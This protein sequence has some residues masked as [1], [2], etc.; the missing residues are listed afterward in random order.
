[1]TAQIV[2]R[3]YMY[4]VAF[5]GLQLM[6]NGARGIIAVMLERSLNAPAIGGVASQTMQMSLFAA[7]LIVGLPLWAGHWWWAQRSLHN[8]DEQHSALRRLYGYA[9]LAV[10]MMS[11]LLDARELI[12]V[13]L[14]GETAGTRMIIVANTIG[15][16]VI[17]STVWLYHWRVFRAD[18]MVVETAGAPAT[19]RRW[20]LVI[21]LAWSLGFASYGAVDVLHQLLHLVGAPG[22]GSTAAIAWA[23]A[24]LIAGLAVWLPHQQWARSLV[25]RQTPLRANEVRSK[26]RQVYGALVITGA[27][28]AALGG[29]ATLLYWA[30]L[31][32]FGGAR[33]QQL[34]TEHTRSFSVVVVAT[35]VW[36]YHRAQLADEAQQSDLAGRTNTARRVV[37]YV[38]ATIG[39][40]GLFIGL[41]GLLSTMLQLLFAPAVFGQ[42]WRNSISFGVA[43]SVVA[44]PMY[45]LA[46][47]DMEHLAQASLDEEQTLARRIY[48]YGMLLFGII[49]TIVAVVS[50]LRLLIGALLG[51]PEPNLGAELARWLGYSV[52]SAT[53]GATYAMLLRRTIGNRAEI[54][55]GETIAIIAE[56]PL[57][58][59]LA[60]AISNELPGAQLQRVD[61]NG[62][63]SL[64]TATTLIVSLSAALDEPTLHALNMFTGRRVLLATETAG[65]NVIGKQT[66]HAVVRAAIRA[67]RTATSDGS[68]VITSTQVA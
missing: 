19:L 18:Q 50:V 60:T 61:A 11:L 40:V 4:I 52:I 32:L 59:A 47:R 34:I 29:L 38:T 13:L 15:V 22:I 6:I 37:G 35:V 63:N 30:L 21:V 17:N 67:I 10:A 25:Y 42:G 55:V 7:L 64:T 65:Y 53:I 9:L 43:L 27:L 5:I 44:F 46:A 24:G 26:L 28:V 57:Q 2:R 8:A 51:I 48:L 54:G 62:K 41:G 56:E 23:L 14:G 39:L 3:L 33:W 31:A 36:W 16:V 12:A 58:T 20:Y 66:A 45:V 49:A 68:Q 1:M